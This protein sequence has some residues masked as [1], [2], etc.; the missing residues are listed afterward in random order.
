MP[1]PVRQS[2]ARTEARRRT[3]GRGS[4]VVGAGPGSDIDLRRATSG[5]PVA[6][7]SLNPAVRSSTVTGRT[8]AFGPTMHRPRPL[9]IDALPS[10][11]D[12]GSSTSYLG[13][14][15]RWI[16]LDRDR[17]EPPIPS[18]TVTTQVLEHTD[19]PVTVWGP[20][21]RR[22]HDD[23]VSLVGARLPVHDASARTCAQPALR[24]AAVW[25]Q[26]SRSSVPR[27]GR[28]SGAVA[29][30]RLDVDDRSETSRIV[31]H[32]DP[33]LRRAGAHP[34]GPTGI[35]D[36]DSP[37]ARSSARRTRE[38]GTVRPGTAQA[39]AVRRWTSTASR[40]TW[41]RRRAASAS[42][43][44]GSTSSPSASA[45]S[46]APPE[47]GHPGLG[48]LEGDPGPVDVDLLGQ[49]GHADQQGDPGAGDTL[50]VTVE[51]HVLL[52]L[53]EATVDG[54]PDVVALGPDHPDHAGLDGA[55]QG[56]VPGQEGDVTL[57]GAQDHLGG[58]PRRAGCAPG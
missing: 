21:G 49:L 58:H 17:P 20:I 5:S 51:R 24:R 4:D 53:G 30:G 55:H 37:V 11:P 3:P 6:D 41:A 25:R 28:G 38:P 22:E 8:D 27:T 35:V 12:I 13:S 43:S 29:S 50:V 7:L 26:P 48:G 19:G 45:R 16:H 56:G 10:G 9:A 2:V 34:R 57:A 23:G 36:I 33:R 15:P 32:D 47:L 18:G 52:D 1:W 42:T 40:R 39:V 44:S 54:D 46:A 14:P 31:T